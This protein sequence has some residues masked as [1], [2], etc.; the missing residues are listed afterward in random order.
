MWFVARSHSAQEA[1]NDEMLQ[2]LGPYRAPSW[3][4]RNPASACKP[5]RRP[6]FVPHR[7]FAE[8]RRGLTACSRSDTKA[9]RL[10]WTSPT[11]RPLWDQSLLSRRRKIGSKMETT[12]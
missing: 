3:L 2:F 5:Y 8:F 10:Q 12:L 9:H 7:R 1:N 6:G 11:L 4:A